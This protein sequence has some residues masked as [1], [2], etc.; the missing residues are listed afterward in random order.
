MKQAPKYHENAILYPSAVRNT[1]E[2]DGRNYKTEAGSMVS[3]GLYVYRK[4]DM[5]SGTGDTAHSYHRL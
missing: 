2:I 1:V 3:V 5:A 4:L